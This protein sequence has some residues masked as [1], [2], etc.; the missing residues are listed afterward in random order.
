[1]HRQ[2]ALIIHGTK[3]EAVPLTHSEHF[4]ALYPSVRLLPVDSG[5]EL[6]DVL[7][8]LG[9]RDCRVVRLPAGRRYEFWKQAETRNYKVLHCT[10]EQKRI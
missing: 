10:V 3:D 2:P 7:E 1:M 8:L 6:T 4:A 5:H 9:T